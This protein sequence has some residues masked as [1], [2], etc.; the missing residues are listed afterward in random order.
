M[1]SYKRNNKPPILVRV[2]QLVEK[3]DKKTALIRARGYLEQ[4]YYNQD[5]LDIIAD[6][7]YKNGNL[8]EAGRYWYF[9]KE[10]NSITR[11]AIYSFEKRY[12]FSKS[13]I[14]R[15]LIFHHFKSPVGFNISTKMVI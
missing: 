8:V 9:S 3:Y 11:K 4:Y 1:F 15:K 6:L 10:D 5:I 13:L 7:E 12:G 2:Q 14:L